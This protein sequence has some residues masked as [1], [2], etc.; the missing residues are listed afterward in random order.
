[1]THTMA[2]NKGLKDNMEPQQWENNESIK[3]CGKVRKTIKG[4]H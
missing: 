3:G 2:I 4:T 1:M